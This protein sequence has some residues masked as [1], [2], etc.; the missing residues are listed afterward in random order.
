M[1]ANRTPAQWALTVALVLVYVATVVVSQATFRIF[2]G[3]RSQLAVVASTL[4]AA[5]LLSPP[6]RRIQRFIDR[7]FYLRNLPRE[8]PR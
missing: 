5:A 7:R 4:V 1:T 3:Q 8:S 2:T 6:W